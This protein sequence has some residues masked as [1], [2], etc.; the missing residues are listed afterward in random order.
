[1]TTAPGKTTIRFKDRTVKVTVPQAIAISAG[2]ILLGLIAGLVL[3]YFVYR[4][5]EKDGEKIAAKRGHELL[6]DLFG[7]E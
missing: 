6:H 3:L 4:T 7:K 5:G 1:V 2:L